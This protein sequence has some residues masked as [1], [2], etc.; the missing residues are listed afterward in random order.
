M[1]FGDHGEIIAD[2]PPLKEKRQQFKGNVI[3][4]EPNSDGL[5]PNGLPLRRNPWPNSQ[6]VPAASLLR[7]IAGS[8]TGPSRT[9]Q[10]AERLALE[11]QLVASFA[12]VQHSEIRLFDSMLYS[13]PFGRNQ[14]HE[15]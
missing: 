13:Q 6:V 8:L 15:S 10:N 7:Y 3:E 2:D 1:I 4:R 12:K 11:F 5:Q 14:C 9:M